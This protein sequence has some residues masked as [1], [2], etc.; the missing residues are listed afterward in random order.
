M[1]SE[2]LNEN[3]EMLPSSQVFVV[4]ENLLAEFVYELIKAQV[5][6]CLDFVIEKLFVEHC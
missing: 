5:N 3:L 2:W 6:F 1:V 4:T